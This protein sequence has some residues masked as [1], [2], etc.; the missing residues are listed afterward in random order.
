MCVF[1]LLFV[2]GITCTLACIEMSFRCSQQLSPVRDVT[3]H[4]AKD[5]TRRFGHLD[6]QVRSTGALLRK[7]FTHATYK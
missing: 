5:R 7:T 6:R 1:L 3:P 2:L 4:F